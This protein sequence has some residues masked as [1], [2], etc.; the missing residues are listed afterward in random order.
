MSRISK[1]RERRA[2]LLAK[3]PPSAARVQ[4]LTAKGELK[5]KE[6]STLADSDEIQVNKFGD[7][8][9]MKAPPGRKTALDV[10]PVNATVAV[11]VQRKQNTMDTDPVLSM[12]RRDP[13]SPDVLH[14]VL[15]GLSEESASLKFER[16]EAAR[17]GK[18]T[19]GLSSKRVLALR[20]VGDTWLKRMDQLSGKLIDLESPAFLAVFKHMMETVREAMTASKLRPEQIESVFAKFSASAGS[21]EWKTEAKNRMKNAVH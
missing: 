13:D 4:V 17:E 3:I 11:L 19:S 14:E 12:T 9:V 7:P 5:Y 8:V 1:D 6:I 15:I 18:D 20:A 10:G 2:D 16:D 21:D